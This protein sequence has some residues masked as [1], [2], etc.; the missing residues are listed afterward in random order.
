MPRSAGIGCKHLW[1]AHAPPHGTNGGK[2]LV[3][4]FWEEKFSRRCEGAPGMLVPYMRRVV[5]EN[6]WNR[7]QTP[8]ARSRTSSTKLRPR[9]RGKPRPLATLAMTIKPS[10]RKPHFSR[11]VRQYTTAGSCDGERHAPRRVGSA[12]RTPL[13]V[14]RSLRGSVTSEHTESAVKRGQPE[15]GRA[16]V[17]RRLLG[18][19]RP[20]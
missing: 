10:P 3:E 9:T 5:A 6:C 1:L 11:A 19:R 2:T 17:Q 15:P 8:L 12:T 16:P 4:M 7:L 20:G 14:P 18:R 13:S